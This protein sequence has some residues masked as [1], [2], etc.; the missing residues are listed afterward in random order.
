MKRKLIAFILVVALIIGVV[1][2][3]LG[4]TAKAAGETGTGYTELSLDDFGI[5]TYKEMLKDGDSV[6][7]S[8]QASLKDVAVTGVYKLS[9]N[10]EFFIGGNYQG[11][12][13]QV[14]GSDLCLLPI[15]AVYQEGK[16]IY[17]NSGV[18]GYD[19]WLERDIELR[20]TFDFDNEDGNI[21]DV[22]VTATVDDCVPRDMTLSGVDTTE[23]KQSIFVHLPDADSKVVMTE[24]EYLIKN[25]TMKDFRIDTS[26]EIKTDRE[27]LTTENDASL[28]ETSVT[29]IYNFTEGAKIYIGGYEQGILVTISDPSL[30]VIPL[31]LGYS[32]T[33][34]EV[35]R[36]FSAGEYGYTSWFGQDIEI[37]TSFDFKNISGDKADVEV[38]VSVNDHVAKVINLTNATI[39]SLRTS[40][41]VQID[42]G[43]DGSVT[44]SEPTVQ[45]LTLEDFGVF[46]DETMTKDGAFIQTESKGTLDGTA[47][48]GKYR[49]EGSGRV[50]IGENWHAVTLYVYEDTFGV[51]PVLLENTNTDE[52]L[53]FNIKEFGYTS[54]AERDITVRV[55]FDFKNISGNKADVVVEVTVDGSVT[56]EMTLKQA[57]TTTLYQNIGVDLNYPGTYSAVTLA[58]PDYVPVT[59]FDELS[60]KDF[61]ISHS[62]IVRTDGTI[63][64][65]GSDASLHGKAVTGKYKL[66]GDAQFFIGD[67]K[68]WAGL[69]VYVWSD[70]NTQETLYIQPSKL[71]NS[72]PTDDKFYPSVLRF[73]L[74]EFENYT[75]WKDRDIKIRAAFEFVNV[76]EEKGKADVV[77]RITIDD[78]VTK[79]MIL[80][81]A[82]TAPLC[83]SIGVYL[84]NGSTIT[85]TEPNPDPEPDYELFTPKDY[86]FKGYT[87]VSGELVKEL[88]SE[89][90]DGTCIT[91]DYKFSPNGCVVCF[92]GYWTGV[93][94]EIA[95]GKLNVKFKLEKDAEVYATDVF[96][97]V[98]L[99]PEEAG[100]TLTDR[101]INLKMGFEVTKREGSMGTLVVR[102]TIDNSF[103][104]QYT[105][106]NVP[107]AFTKQT[108]MAWSSVEGTV[109]LNASDPAPAAPTVNPAFK[110]LTFD[111]YTVYS[112]VYGYN[113][114][115]DLLASGNCGLDSLDKVVFSDTI[116][117]TDKPGANLYIGGKTDGWG[118]LLLGSAE[119]GKLALIY[120][121]ITITFTSAEAE[122]QLTDNDVKI[123]FSF[124]YV[125]ADEDGAT[126]D[127]K[128]GVWFNGKAYNNQWIYLNDYADKLGGFIGISSAAEGAALTVK[129]YNAPIDFAEWGFTKDWAKTLGLV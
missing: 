14:Y 27:V 76:L 13:V 120:D 38:S 10:A 54:W 55:A 18:F 53:F 68:E 44:L 101:V 12:R 95:E 9:G 107:L 2:S 114:S 87:L 108:M 103:I 100:M 32:E 126:D 129:T 48:T 36:Y 84:P 11:V 78:A 51:I 109:V 3:T 82:D 123:T 63:I 47:V 34:N 110:Q 83:Q 81:D 89:T 58:N 22:V 20:L 64:K 124:E 43:T 56:K 72:N 105:F 111:S 102:M 70:E 96:G 41:A 127:V 17:F 104:Q 99:T 118:G 5:S 23:L 42:P 57:T 117:I 7:T 65:T 33:L 25:L 16:G 15:G 80:K 46:A 45:E 69:H 98:E 60:L 94:I 119:N 50:F 113:G 116:N 85:M 121:G 125:D 74:S 73:A 79:T 31:G 24:P 4:T 106:E 61:G 39:S 35:S 112:G 91:G 122:V 6:Q 52:G 67:A 59:D 28:N 128:L 115:E 29:G 93:Y 37:S 86:G 66:S 77:V 62:R 1:P 30:C 90:L 71:N 40:I 92:G 19:S 21:A 49:F 8:T 97:N 88:S 26:R 75:S